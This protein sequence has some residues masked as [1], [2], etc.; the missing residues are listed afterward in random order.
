MLP[1][2]PLD[3]RDDAAADHGTDV[4]RAGCHR[5]GETL[6]AVAAKAV[7][8]AESGTDEF[9]GYVRR[10]VDNARGLATELASRGAR[11]VSG[12]TDIH[13]AVVDVSG[14]GISGMEAQH[15][16]GAAGIVAVGA[17]KRVAAQ[18]FPFTPN[19]RLINDSKRS[20]IWP[21]TTA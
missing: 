17:A 7:A 10:A 1:L 20:P 18:S 6:A 11:V 5:P 9:A 16:L 2:D 8:C 19:R 15:R 14:F 3:G 21:A 13:L 12:G 4:G